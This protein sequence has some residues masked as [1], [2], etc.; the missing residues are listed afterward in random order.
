MAMA[1]NKTVSLSRTNCNSVISKRY[2]GLAEPNCVMVNLHCQGDRTYNYQGNILL[3]VG[4]G[5]C[6]KA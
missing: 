3:D 6:R 5:V 4:E 1:T 2:P